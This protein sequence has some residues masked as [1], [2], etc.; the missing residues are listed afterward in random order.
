MIDIHGFEFQ[1]HLVK[2]LTNTCIYVD[3]EGNS[4]LVHKID[5]GMGKGRNTNKIKGTFNLIDS[6]RLHTSPYDFVKRNG[7]VQLLSYE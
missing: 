3:D 6:Q 5:L 4:Y 2:E 1:G 7:G